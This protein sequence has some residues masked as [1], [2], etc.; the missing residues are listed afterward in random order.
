MIVAA[1]YTHML[2]FNETEKP[3]NPEFFSKPKTRFLVATTRFFGFE[4]YS[5]SPA[6]WQFN[7]ST[8]LLPSKN[9]DDPRLT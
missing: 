1:N 6:N 5:K 4:F 9:I 7:A 3:G 8:G 2:D